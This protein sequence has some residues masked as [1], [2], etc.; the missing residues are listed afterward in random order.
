MK[1][2]T[3]PPCV[4]SYQTRLRCLLTLAVALLLAGQSLL[5]ATT[6]IPFPNLGEMAKAADAVVVAVADDNYQ[7]DSGD[8]IYFR[9]RFRITEP[10]KGTFLQGE[11][12]ELQAFREISMGLERHIWGDPEF[13][14]GKTYL[15]FLSHRQVEPYW[16]PMMLAYGIFEQLTDNDEQLFV[17]SAMSREIHTVRRPDGVEVEPLAVY[18][19][20]PLVKML[21]TVAQGTTTWDR[22]Q[23]LA[24][25]EFQDAFLSQKVA[26]SH[27]TFLG[28]PPARYTGFPGNPIVLYSEDDGDNSFSPASAVHTEVTNAVAD[29]EANYT[30]I[31]W[32][33]SGLLNYTPNCNGGGAQGGNFCSVIGQREAIVI[34]NDPCSQITD[35]SNCSGT[36]AIGGLYTS[37]T[38]IYDGITWSTGYKSYVV[39]NNDIGPLS[40]CLTANQY[41]IML[42]HELTHCLGTGHID[43]S[44]GV[45]NMNP[46]CCNNINT[47]DIQCLDYT[48]APALPVE[49]ISFTALKDA[50]SVALQWSTASERNNDHF[51]VQRSANGLDFQTLVQIP[52][53]GH[54]SQT[55]LY[56]YVDNNP[57]AGHNYYRLQQV[58]ADGQHSY[59]DI[60][61]VFF[62]I[63][64]KEV[65]LF[66]NPMKNNQ[67]TIVFSS[68]TECRM[69]L[70]LISTDGSVQGRQNYFLESG[71]NHIQYNTGSLYPGVYWLRL[72]CGTDVFMKR[73]VK[74]QQ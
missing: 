9:T 46:S 22:T 29:M 66:P 51:L 65:T 55:R 16:Q 59:S 40:N 30:G 13:E 43:P 28:S 10:V 17:P 47:P 68:P 18:K 21:K 25:E 23:V 14:E 49:L 61:S 35:L 32:N 8:R 12:F 20:L 71:L 44:N 74:L 6:I 73:V 33:Y 48:Y 41:K 64:K 67:L 54:S 15:L 19:A 24:N 42:T 34:Y 63:D 50:R 60:R 39:V 70:E 4:F 1:V 45:A 58:D 5:W 31:D 36:L 72:S 3:L 27:C 38:H 56:S 37:G 53:A 7:S 26:P 62:E 2:F 69:N 11:Y 52:G 57:A